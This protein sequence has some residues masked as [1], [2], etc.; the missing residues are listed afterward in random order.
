VSVSVSVNMQLN[1]LSADVLLRGSGLS[2]MCPGPES[3]R[4][5]VPVPVLEMHG[6]SQLRKATLRKFGLVSDAHL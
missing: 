6:A 2:S 4:K 1:R 5:P 3:I